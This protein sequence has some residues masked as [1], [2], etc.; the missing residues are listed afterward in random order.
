VP[1]RLRQV[2]TSLVT[3]AREATA[4]GGTVTV[5]TGHDNDQLWVEVEDDGE[6]IA[7]EHMAHLF[8]PFFTTKPPGRIRGLDLSL[9]H[10][11]VQAH[12][13]TMHVTS[14]LGKGTLFRIALPIGA[15]EGAK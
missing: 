15:P 10:T 11:I 5:R 2:I 4:S 12:G 6:G 3:N 14:E 13:G 8:E 1:D 7:P 9:S